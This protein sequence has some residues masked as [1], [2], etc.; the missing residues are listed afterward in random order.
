MHASHVPLGWSAPFALLL[1]AIAVLPL[2]AGHWWEHNR[3]KGIV[4]ALLAAP[5]AWWTA[6][7]M[8]HALQHAGLEYVSFILLLGSLFVVSGG[9]LLTGDLRARPGVNT[10]FLAVGA[11]LANLVGTTGASMLLIRPLLRTNAQREHVVHTVVFFVF[12]VCNTGGLLTPLGDPPLF[13]GFLRGVPFTWTFTLFPFW[14]GVNAAL[15]TIYSVWDSRA[16]RRETRSDLRA[17]AASVEPLRLAGKR[18]LILL[19]AI[20]AAVAFAPPVW[21]ESIM[22]AAALASLV[23]TPRDVHARNR[24]AWGPIVE[25]AV[26]FAGIFVTMVPAL[27]WLEQNGTALGVTSPRQFFWVTGV[28]SSFLDNTP[29]YVTFA[30]VATSLVNG[31]HPGAGITPDAL[32]RLLDF[33]EG[34]PLLRA[35]S[36]GA[37]LM[38]A[39]TYIGNGPNFMV[40]AIADASGV[41]TPAFFGYML[42]SVGI[43]LPVLAVVSIFV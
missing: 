28:L 4:C 24:F 32:G 7:A 8:P 18:N 30:S 34:E 20:V 5:V 33:P 35:I 12:V 31:A 2:A 38:G 41:K 40:K 6:T 1:L 43:L 16:I 29:T 36:L 39:N 26:L 14:L 37:V 27:A 3:N 25:V 10:A 9:L 42:W 13:M 19:A 22:L 21:R 23:A 15:L 17:D 11:V